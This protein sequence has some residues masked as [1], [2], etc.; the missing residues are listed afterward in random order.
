[1]L[2][3]IERQWKELTK[4]ATTKVDCEN[5]DC[6]YS[7]ITAHPVGR[8]R[9]RCNVCGDRLTVTAWVNRSWQPPAL[10]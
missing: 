1:M 7:L 2:S 8:T 9:T 4:N 5:P 3:W 6:T 10:D